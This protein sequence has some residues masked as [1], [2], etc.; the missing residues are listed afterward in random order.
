MQDGKETVREGGMSRI[1]RQELIILLENASNTIDLLL[2]RDSYCELISKDGAQ[3]LAKKEVKKI[4]DMLN[5]WHGKPG[6]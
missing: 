3:D 4:N 6:T 1:T 5:K 2:N